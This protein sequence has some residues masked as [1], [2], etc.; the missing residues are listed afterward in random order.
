MT[1]ESFLSN[2]DSGY[3]PNRFQVEIDGI[4][5]RLKFL[6]RSAT[7]P[8][9]EIG[10]IDV[11]YQGISI[12]IPGDRPGGRTW[13]IEV[14]ADVNFAVRDDLELWSELIRPQEIPGGLNVVGAIRT[15]TVDLLGT[16]G[17]VLRTYRMLR[18]WP[19]V[20]G[21][22]S[23]SH[24]TTDTIAVYPITFTFTNWSTII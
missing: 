18:C 23:L 1:I 10:V 16:N 22:L 11:P 19:S 5:T 2:F 4:D 8:S 20:I 13:E 17:E 14:F 15:A 21:E 24:D 7:I 12:P 9:S 6:C 3:R